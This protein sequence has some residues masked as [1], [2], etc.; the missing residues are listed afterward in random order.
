VLIEALS[1]EQ[2]ARVLA[3]PYAKRSL[4]AHGRGDAVKK[5]QR[6]ADT[7]QTRVDGNKQDATLGR[8]H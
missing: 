5:L 2:Q 1:S 3:A 4:V 6:E 7:R 8:A